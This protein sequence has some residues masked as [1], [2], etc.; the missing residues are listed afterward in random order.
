MNNAPGQ[1]RRGNRP[2][3]YNRKLCGVMAGARTD[4]VFR[5]RCGRSSRGFTAQD[6]ST[7]AAIRLGRGALAA[8]GARLRGGAES[9]L[10]LD[11][12]RLAAHHFLPRRASRE[13]IRLGEA[14]QAAFWD[15]SGPAGLRPNAR[16]WRVARCCRHRVSPAQVIGPAA[17][18][19]WQVFRRRASA[20]D[21]GFSPFQNTRGHQ[22]RS[23]CLRRPPACPGFGHAADDRITAAALPLRPLGNN[24]NFCTARC[25]R[26]LDWVEGA[27]HKDS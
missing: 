3:L 15:C 17:C 27:A 20:G 16:C 5:G 2:A 19:S 1:R 25:V 14:D 12:R 18:R 21:A 11:Q 13:A 22:D 9:S 7:P 26:F 23:A 24:R 4:V 10:C 6:R 8:A